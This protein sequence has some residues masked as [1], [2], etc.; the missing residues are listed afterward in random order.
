MRS[1]VAA[2][3]VAYSVP[4]LA[5][6]PDAAA[7][8]LAD[9][10]DTTVA[11]PSNWRAFVEAAAIHTD[12][13]GA[14]ARDA[15]RLSLDVHY[16]AAWAPGWRAVFADR[17]DGTWTRGDA[18][19][20][21][22]NTFKEAYLSWQPV[23]QQIFDV[24]RVNVRHGIATGYNP[25]DFFRGGAV[26]SVVSADPA[27]L[28]ENRLG[29]VLVRGQWLWN[30]GSV[31][32]LYSPRIEDTPNPHAYSAD[33]GST[34]NRNR[35]LLTGSARV[36]ENFDPQWLIYGE[37]HEAPQF[38][39]NLTTLLNDAT[40]VYLEW[41]GGRA[42]SLFARATAQNGDDA[43]RQ[44]TATGLSYTM[45][46]KLSVT[47]EYQHNSAA[48]D[49]AAWQNLWQRT[50]LLY[51][52]YRG[53]IQSL[54]EMP[55]RSAVFFYGKWQDALIPHLDLTGMV[56]SNAQDRSRFIWLEFRYHWDRVD[57]ALQ[58]QRNGGVTGSEYGALPE[59]SVWTALATLYF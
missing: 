49:H 54:Q 24:G 42:E 2:L 39:L 43:F 47:L 15:R 18:G 6:D 7:L 10:T 55:T 52:Q 53:V 17:L 13:R 59:K 4:V 58:H 44:R 28:R 50:P 14:P 26:R 30:G 29:T 32:A 57:I 56:R 35:W 19:H 25:T 8:E 1:L 22:I 41:S 48:L 9:R 20:D 23:P 27:S 51:W 16:D 46:N 40:V 38:G 11:R 5:G 34:N 36:S 3:L 33:W 31:A 12:W 45:P 21:E 37:E